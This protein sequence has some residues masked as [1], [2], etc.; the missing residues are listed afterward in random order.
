LFVC[1]FVCF[2]FAGFS[3]TR[4]LLSMHVLSFFLLC[5]FGRSGRSS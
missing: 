5:F 3:C 2:L 1:L 4:I